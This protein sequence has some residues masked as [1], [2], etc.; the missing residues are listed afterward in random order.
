MEHLKK[1]SCS[2]LVFVTKEKT[3]LFYLALFPENTRCFIK[4][5]FKKQQQITFPSEKHLSNTEETKS[6]RVLYKMIKCS[7]VHTIY[8]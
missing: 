7:L 6:Q 4:N 1:K 3:H 8:A 5:L 2:I